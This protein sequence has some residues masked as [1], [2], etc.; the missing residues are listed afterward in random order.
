MNPQ[1]AK[2]AAELISSGAVVALKDGSFEVAGAHGTYRISPGI[3]GAMS[4][5]CPAGRSGRC[6]H[7]IAVLHKQKES[8]KQCH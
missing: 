8:N 1:T 5:G 6:S 7:I 3:D 4:C 2:K